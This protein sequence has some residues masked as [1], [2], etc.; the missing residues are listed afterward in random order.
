MQRVA[1]GVA[2]LMALT[3]LAASM[4]P[5]CAQ[6]ALQRRD[7][8]IPAGALGP[9]I[10]RL[11]R[12]AGVA[13]TFDPAL[14]SGKTTR[15]VRGGLTAAEALRRLLQ[16]TG[17]R[18]GSDGAG[19]FVLL[20]LPVSADEVQRPSEPATDIL[21]IG[22]GYGLEVG[23][24]S[25][26]PLRETP[27][28]VTVV[29]QDRIQEQNLF[30]IT[31][32]A[33]QTVGLTTTGGDSDLAQFMS[34]GFTIDN[35]LVDGVP[36]NGFTGEIPDLFLYDRVEILRGPAG[37]FSGSGSPAG[38]INLVRKRP[39]P[40]LTVKGLA[41]AGSWNNYRG[42][43]DVSG[44]LSDR[45]GVRA[46]LAY[47]DRDQFYDV[48]HQ[49]RLLAFGVIDLKPGETT[50]LTLGG[51]HDRYRGATFSGL[52]GLAGPDGQA[53]PLPELP[54][55]TY[56][57]AD[58]NKSDFDT[59]AGFAEIRQELG[60]RW[61]G[62]LS[63]TYGKT[64]TDLITSYA[65]AFG[66]ITPTNGEAFLLASRL[67]RDQ[68]YFTA[69]L[70]FVGSIPLFGRDH[71]MLIG[72]DYQRKT[73][74]EGFSDRAFLGTFDLYNPV[75]SVPEPDFPTTSITD[76]RIEQYG[77]YGQLRLKLADGLTFV[78][79][80]R[81][82]WYKNDVTSILPAGGT[83]RIEVEGRFTPY[84]GLVYDA[85][86]RWTLYASYA[87]TFAPQT[88]R[89][90]EGNPLRP[91]TGKQVEL[92]VKKGLFDDRLLV[93]AALYRIEQT[94]RPQP[95]PRDINFSIASGKVRSEGIEIEVNGK[96]A[97]GWNLH[98]GYALNNN[99]YLED[100]ALE[101]QRFTLAMPKHSMKLW[102]NYQPSG[103]S[104]SVGGGLRWQ[105][106]MEAF[107]TFLGGTTGARQPSYAVIDLRAGYDLTDHVALGVNLN[108]LFDKHYYERVSGTEFGN[109]YGA[110]RNILV[111]ARLR[112]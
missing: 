39:L 33:T 40:T 107:L 98:A 48:A 59:T 76:T 105:S 58:W 70:N 11:G 25:L 96:L 79:G 103:Q 45:I 64:S 94:G 99:R 73:L 60:S 35:Y 47:Q 29:D 89:T 82:N 32:L 12:T 65:A 106:E 30:T 16:G 68:D 75:Y 1:A 28:T 36:N 66:G 18:A 62:R 38:S 100:D 77:L 4:A 50:T 74:T 5:A 22:K 83:S 49:S 52:P 8:D 90:Y 101:G 111:T 9:A 80:G 26:A 71:D 14:A 55:S 56:A 87:E 112:Y 88:G 17:L 102:T 53:N 81:L 78:P 54:R 69:D 61:V 95:D 42:E 43:Y 108:N 72:A 15:G 41:A 13:I 63:A 34:R 44:P 27:N 92:G 7:Y 84:A 85:G 86:H 3:G 104:W 20:P 2:A 31:D 93:S 110:P 97:P 37:L 19:G 51:H 23:A 67:T 21:V 24:K 57:A 6:E 10:A 91:V 109:F 46:G